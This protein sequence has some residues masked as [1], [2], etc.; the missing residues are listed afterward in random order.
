[1]TDLKLTTCPK[2]NSNLAKSIEAINGRLRPLKPDFMS[3]T[4][5][6]CRLVVKTTTGEMW[7]GVEK[8]N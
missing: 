1:M 3:C 7:K 4:N 2:C 5:A 8:I 6:A